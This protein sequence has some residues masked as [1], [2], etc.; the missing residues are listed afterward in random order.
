[1]VTGGIALPLVGEAVAS[2]VTY[3]TAGCA[4]GAIIAPGVPLIERRMMDLAE[5]AARSWIRYFDR[6]ATSVA[7]ARPI[8]RYFP[9]MAALPMATSLLPI[10]PTLTHVTVCP[11]VSPKQRLLRLIGLSQRQAVASLSIRALCCLRRPTASDPLAVRSASN[12]VDRHADELLRGS[13]GAGASPSPGR[14]RAK[15]RSVRARHQRWRGR[16]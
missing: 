14:C 13:I 10:T 4:V 7:Y 3:F 16:K 1:M 11:G 5:W 8:R 9:P 6:Q 15:F 2:F 12:C